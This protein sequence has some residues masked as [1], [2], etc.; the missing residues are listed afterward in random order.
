MCTGLRKGSYPEAD[1]LR[2]LQSM[3]LEGQLP[4]EC[5]LEKDHL[6]CHRCTIA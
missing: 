5:P 4:C 2:H 3:C 6:Q 1:E